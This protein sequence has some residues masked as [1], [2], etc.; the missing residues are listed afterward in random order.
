MAERDFTKTGV[1]GLDAILGGGIPRG[2]LTLVE[3]AVGTGKSTLGAEFVFRGATEFHE[4]GLIV[5]FE[6][7]PDKFIRDVAR[8]GW[9]LPEPER[10]GRP[11]MAFTTRPVFQQAVQQADSL[12]PDE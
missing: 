6:G 3:G 9:D 12:P 4:P 1:K 10:Q 7:S 11:K 8:F 5:L 2:N